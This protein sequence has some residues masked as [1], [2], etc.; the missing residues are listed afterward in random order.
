MT[1]R[2][3]ATVTDAASAG[4]AS[5]FCRIGPWTTADVGWRG[6]DAPLYEMLRFIDYY[7]TIMIDISQGFVIFIAV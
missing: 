3:N 1:G 7:N 2:S 4:G 5:L 6:R